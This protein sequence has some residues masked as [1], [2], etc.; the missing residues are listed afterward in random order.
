MS[1]ALEATG[2]TK[3]FGGVAAVQDVSLTV[4]RGEILGVIGPNG[5]GKS[6]LFGMLAGHLKPSG[7]RVRLEG[8]DVTGDRPHRICK[9]G[10]A[11]THQI[12]RPF[13]DLTVDENVR[14][15]ARFGSDG[16]VDPVAVIRRCGL[17]Q[18][19][20]T[21]SAELTHAEQRKL[22]FGRA[23]A[24]QPRVLLL[25]EVGAGL[26]D[27]ELTELDAVIKSIRDEGVAL[28]VVEHIMSLVMGISDRI[29]VMNA[30]KTIAEGTPAQVAEDPAVITAY[31]GAA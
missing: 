23:L 11:R 20:R 31:L 22:E 27:D 21:I 7:G 16:S 13:A 2:L 8:R 1:A 29:L 6:T 15:A 17:E 9:A 18:R 28:V 19:A 12:P 30:G 26:T 24:T 5:A 25:D 3:R 10:L 4:D 14:I